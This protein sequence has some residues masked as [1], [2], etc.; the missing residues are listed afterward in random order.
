[1]EVKQLDRQMRTADVCV[2][3]WACRCTVVTGICVSLMLSAALYLA[4]AARA[5]ATAA[6]TRREEDT[7]LM[8]ERAT[9][10][11]AGAEEA[12]R[13]QCGWQVP[14]KR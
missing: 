10:W 4:A 3:P 6:Q 2:G 14:R 8:S 1:M 12:V 11:L 7:G 9:V 5:T 13:K